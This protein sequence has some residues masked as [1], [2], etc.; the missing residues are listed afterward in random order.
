LISNV[1]GLPTAFVA[2]YGTRKPVIALLAEYD[3]LEGLGHA[4]GHHLIAGMSTLA[5][6]GIAKVLDP[7]EGTIALIGC[8]AEETIGAKALLVKKGIFRNIDVAMMIH[9]S[10]KTE[11]IKL[12]L[13]LE[14]FSVVFKG[15]TSH[16]SATPWKGKNTLSAMISLFQGIDANRITL[17]EGV[18][19]NGVIKKGGVAANIIPDISEAEFFVRAKDIKSHKIA[20]K[21][22]YHT[23]QG[24]ALALGVSY[25]IKRIG[26]IYYPLKPN[27]TLAHH[28]ES[29][30]NRLHINIDNFF[31]DREL[32]SSDIGNVSQV[33]PV[34]HPTLA[35]TKSSCPAHSRA[36][37]LQADKPKAYKVMKSGAILL[38]LTAH[39]LYKDK[40]LL[41]NIKKEHY[42]KY[43]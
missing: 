34:I 11:V 39:G 41:S 36:F 28:F 24:T 9:P 40:V 42:I 22:F 1:R 6:I 18:K 35:I 20:V 5:A 12:S 16:A 21:R 23:V 10:D 27:I 17:Q 19:I 43:S 37:K 15:L 8:P 26:N 33:V 31:T 29:Q 32:G 38:A 14:R 3:A 7:D 2:T 4:C 13:S 25:M 30:L